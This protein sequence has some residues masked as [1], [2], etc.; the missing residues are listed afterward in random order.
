MWY[1]CSPKIAFSPFN[2]FFGPL[3]WLTS[4]FFHHIDV[5]LDM[6]NQEVV[7]N[8]MPRAPLFESFFPDMS[9]GSEC[10][11]VFSTRPLCV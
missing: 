11:V 7:H 4:C 3:V 9:Q 2:D 10:L 6:F 1:A 8:P 5:G